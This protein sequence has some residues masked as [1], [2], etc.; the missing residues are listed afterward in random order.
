[1]SDEELDDLVR[2]CSALRG[3]RWP[4]TPLGELLGGSVRSQA[5]RLGVDDAQVSRWKRAGLSD[6]MADR[7]AIRAGLHP[8]IVWPDWDARAGEQLELDVA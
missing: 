3:H 8:A 2:L 4:W 1:M 7:C 6:A 5:E